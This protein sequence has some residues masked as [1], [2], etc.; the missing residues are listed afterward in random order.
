MWEEVG[1]DGVAGFVVGRQLLLVLADH[2]ALALRP[3]HYT[4]DRLREFREGDR[5]LLSTR[6][7][8]SRLVYEV[9]Q[10]GAAEAGRL[11]AHYLEVD[12][13]A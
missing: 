1:D 10:I 5:S 6:C 7:E 13:V 2:P 12:V 4:V 8:N 11:L 3:R 9:G